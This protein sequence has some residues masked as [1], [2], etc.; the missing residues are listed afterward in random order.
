MS[1]W[2][3]LLLLAKRCL[4]KSSTVEVPALRREESRDTAA[5]MMVLPGSRVWGSL[6]G[7]QVKH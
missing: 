6:P 2:F 3:P 1:F 7:H 4:L 5:K